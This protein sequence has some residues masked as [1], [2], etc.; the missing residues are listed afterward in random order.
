MRILVALLPLVVAGLLAGCAGP[1]KQWMKVGES[2]S[3]AEFRRD[4]AACSKSGR[5]DEDCLRARGWVDMSPTKADRAA[6]AP[7]PPPVSPKYQN[8]GTRPVR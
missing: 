7:P 3:T 1:D 2:Y 6:D 4:Y 5:L 8:S